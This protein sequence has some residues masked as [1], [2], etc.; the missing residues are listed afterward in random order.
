[1]GRAWVFR[2][3]ISVKDSVTNMNLKSLLFFGS[4]F[5]PL[6]IVTLD[7]NG[8]DILAVLAV[9]NNGKAKLRTKMVDTGDTLGNFNVFGPDWDAISVSAVPDRNAD[10]VSE[11]G[12]LARHRATGNVRLR[13]VDPLTGIVLTT[14]NYPSD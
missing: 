7:S 12:V 11:A 4:Q 9:S 13:V 3:E 14:I 5:R 2:A 1:M 8:T 6:D 10:G